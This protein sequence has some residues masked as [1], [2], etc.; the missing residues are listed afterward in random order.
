VIPASLTNRGPVH[1]PV[2]SLQKGSARFHDLEQQFQ[3]RKMAEETKVLQAW[4]SRIQELER[5]AM[6]QGQAFSYRDL[7]KAVPKLEKPPSDI[8]DRNRSIAQYKRE[9]VLMA[10]T[11]RAA[12]RDERIHLAKDR[13]LFLENV[14]MI[15]S[16]IDG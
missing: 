11:I 5:E 16:R 10:N 8:I 13:Y 12:Q 3:D 7:E 6:N 14:M 9:N 4:T 1:L 2:P 15:L